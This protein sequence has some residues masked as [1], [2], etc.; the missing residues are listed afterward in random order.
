MP[1][2][3][4][5]HRHRRR[6]PRPRHRHRPLTH[7]EAPCYL[8]P[9]STN[10][11]THDAAAS[12]DAEATGAL[13]TGRAEAAGKAFSELY[14]IVARLRA[15]DGCPWDREQSP[16]SLRGSLIE[17]T[18][19]LV[20]AIDEADPAHVAEEAGDLFLLATMISYMHEERGLFAVSDALVGLAEKLIRR[21]PH[22]F[23]NVEAKDSAEVLRQWG[24]IKEK[25]E[26]RRKKDSLLDGVP[27]SLPPLERAYKLQKRAAKVG[28]DWTRS[29]DV[30][31]KAREELHEAEEACEEAAGRGD[32]EAL[33]DELGDL[34]FSA[35]NVARFLD[36][37]PALALRRSLAKFERRFRHVETGM[38]RSGKPLV[39][40]AGSEEGSEELAARVAEMNRYW[41]EAKRAE[42]TAH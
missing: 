31:A 7:D 36:I 20:E 14:R 42:T 5:R 33:E 12:P 6:R 1:R 34:L 24:E 35:I 23:G 16:E 19:E 41:E 2:H 32:R 38:A 29:S 10:P 4:H 30:W 17:E 37:D 15:P 28:F 9:M 39:P 21:H 26:G 22:V 8:R 27:A 40:V 25:V 3:R 18:Y 13:P 11:S